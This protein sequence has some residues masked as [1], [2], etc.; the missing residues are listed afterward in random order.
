MAL[1]QLSFVGNAVDSASGAGHKYDSE[2]FVTLNREPGMAQEQ[3]F[4]PPPAQDVT[5][6]SSSS[7]SRAQ[8][9]AGQLVQ[10]ITA[11]QSNP[12]NGSLVISPRTQELA[13]QL[14]Q[15]VAQ[16]PAEQA[17]QANTP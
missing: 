16:L 15:E 11:A 10:E 5:V 1:W 2:V 17:A 4:T 8:A 3:A 7:S 14:V 9:L 12:D 13:G 6:L